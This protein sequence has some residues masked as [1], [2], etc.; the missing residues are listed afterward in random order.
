MRL[1]D[2]TTLEI[3]SDT[4]VVLTR[5]FGAPRRLVFEAMTRPEHVRRWYGLRV[6]EMVVCEIDLRVGGRWR[7]VLREPGGAE[8]GFSGEYREITPAERLVSTEYYEPVGPE[9]DLLST[10]TFAEHDDRTTVVNH[11]RYR[12]R[13]DR[14]AHLQSGMETGARETMDRLDEL[15]QALVASGD[16]VAGGSR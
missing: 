11:L 15:L 2:P 16:P 4:E 3:R 1:G 9:H 5:S 13:E 8:H 12:C 10:V 7:Y 6:L 14:D